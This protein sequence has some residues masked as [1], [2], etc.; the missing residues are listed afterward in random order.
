MVIRI[1]KAAEQLFPFLV[2]EPGAQ[3]PDAV[4]FDSNAVWGRMAAARLG[5]PMISFM[6]TFMVGSAELKIL[7]P[8]EWVC[9]L[10]PTVPDL[11]RALA[12]RQR[13]VRRF[14]KDIY[15]PAP[16]FPMRGDLT[17]FPV[18]RHLQPANPRLDASCVF[19]GPTIDQDTR[20]SHLD[21]ELVAHLDGADPVVLVSLGTLHAGTDEFFR[22]CFDALSDLPTRILL[23]VGGRTDPA[24]LGTPP[25]NTVVRRF[26]PQLEV[27][28][29]TSVFVTHGGMNSVLEA[30]ANAV[31]LVA[32]PQQVEQL[33]IGHA[34]AERGAGVVL[35]HNLS[36]RPVPAAELRSAVERALADPMMSAAAKS[37]SAT[38]TDGGGAAAGADAIQDLLAGDHR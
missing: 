19:I 20:S 6:T 27:L 12:A 4:A 28:R 14:G 29:A 16:T 26:V 36:K 17:I 23:V 18:P 31:P 25:A 15:P 32:V 10:R 7:R 21:A 22:T 33:V 24:G 9:S 2:T 35:R 1:L 37:I 34:I 11:P 13:L 8:R 30:L 5:L 3:R 38:L